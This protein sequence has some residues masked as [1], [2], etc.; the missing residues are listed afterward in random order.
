MIIW[1]WSG[2]IKNVMILTIVIVTHLE[3]V[4]ID[5]DIYFCSTK[6]MSKKYNDKLYKEKYIYICVCDIIGLMMMIKQW[7]LKLDS[8]SLI[9][10]RNINKHIR[11]Y[12]WIFYY[13]NSSQW[14]YLHPKHILPAFESGEAKTLPQIQWSDSNDDDP[15]PLW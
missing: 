10:D 2:N 6:K 5:N 8:V 12:I 4:T 13:I 11:L 1:Q 14:N 3:S 15:I 9:L 7:Q